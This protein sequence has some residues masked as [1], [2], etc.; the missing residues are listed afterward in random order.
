MR[1][2][3]D[4]SSENAVKTLQ[5]LL[6]SVSGLK[7]DVNQINQNLNVSKSIQLADEV[8]KQIRL[9]QV[10][11]LSEFKGKTKIYLI[12]IRIIPG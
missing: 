12:F 4:T 1:T 8:Q 5:W 7:T 2:V 6:K 11:T 9:V 10:L 3:R